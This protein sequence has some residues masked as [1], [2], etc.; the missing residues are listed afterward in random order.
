MISFGPNVNARYTNTYF[1]RSFVVPDASVFTNLI[2]RVLRDDGCVVYLNSNEVFRSNLPGGVI[3]STTFASVAAPDDGTIYYPTNVSPA[4]LVSGTNFLAVEMH[5]SAANSSDLS[6]DLDLVGYVPAP[7][8]RATAAPGTVELAWPFWA[9]NY[10]LQTAT[11]LSPAAWSNAAAAVTL[12][13]GQLRTTLS[14]SS[15]AQ[16]FRLA[17]PNP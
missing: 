17:N 14:T 9:T 3:T 4:L 10:L 7:Q 11:V 8:I 13:N 2:V 6:F 12:T 5:Q 1:R 15:N 16:F